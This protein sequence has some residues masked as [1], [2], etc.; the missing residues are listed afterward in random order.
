MTA[1]AL[2]VDWKI[3]RAATDGDEAEMQELVSIYLRQGS[4][5]LQKLRAAVEQENSQQVAE[6]AHG[7]LGSSRFFGA[8]QIVKPLTALLKLGR[9][10]SLGSAAAELVDQTEQEFVRIDQFFKTPRQKPSGRC[11][12]A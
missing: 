4:K 7:F 11:D 12:H 9:A 10:D 3:L 1:H 8:T 6:L 5:N 2:P